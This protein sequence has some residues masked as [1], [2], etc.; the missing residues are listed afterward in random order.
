MSIQTNGACL[1]KKISDRRIRTNG[2]SQ[3]YT[4]QSFKIIYFYKEKFCFANFSINETAFEFKGSIFS[5]SAK[6]F[7][8]IQITGKVFLTRYKKL[9]LPKFE[10]KNSVYVDNVVYT[11]LSKHN[12]S[13]PSK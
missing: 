9:L 5:S 13:T 12:I 1:K 6:N 7:P 2:S 11:S 8:R 3:K 4:K 10:F